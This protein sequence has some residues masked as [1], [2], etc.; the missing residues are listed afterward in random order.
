MP[1][2]CSKHGFTLAH[3]SRLMP[4]PR[5]GLTLALISMSMPCSKRGLTLAHITLVSRHGY[6]IYSYDSTRSFNTSN[7]VMHIHNKTGHFMQYQLLMHNNNGIVIITCNL[8][9]Y[10]KYGRLV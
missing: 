6:P 7:L 10:T 4:C 8:P 5:Q 9:H 3:I 2:P 1:M